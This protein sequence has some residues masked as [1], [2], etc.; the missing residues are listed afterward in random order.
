MVKTVYQM[1]EKHTTLACGMPLQGTHEM[2]Y[3][4][5]CHEPM[6]IVIVV[7]VGQ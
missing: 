6:H 7:S 4:V 2:I 5:I 3:H 1:T